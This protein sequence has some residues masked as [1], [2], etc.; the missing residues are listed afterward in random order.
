M[1]EHEVGKKKNGKKGR[2]RIVT[3]VLLIAAV[4]VMVFAIAK[5]I[6][7]L[8]DYRNS[9]DTYMD[10]AGDI[11]DAGTNGEETE[12]EEETDWS[13]V[14]IDFD[15]LKAINSDVV[16]WIRFDDTTALPIDYPIL[17]GVT[18]DTYL[19]TNLYG[20]PYTAGS[21]FL[22]SANSSDLSDLY[23]IIY[24][25]NMRNNSMFGSLKQYK[26]NEDFYGEN[27]F[28]T[29]YTEEGT[30][31]YQIFAYEEIKD[32]S[33]FYSVGYA[34]DDAYQDLIDE[35]VAGSMR[36]TGITPTAGDRIV[37]L[38]TCTSTGDDYR[39]VVF[40]VCTEELTY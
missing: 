27:Q 22:E 25:H 30:Y 4:A 2:D 15:S 36:D 12:D 3:T 16:G 21:I 29:I 5:L 26:R 13:E 17:Q 31:R 28:F 24:G 37:M 14:V 18:D 7:I 20:E 39:F 33:S 34:A 19:R 8:M 23:N 11:V 40:G 9:D 1:S 32:D 10:L 6:P 38:S 35:I